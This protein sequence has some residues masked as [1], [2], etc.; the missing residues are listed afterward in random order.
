MTSVM[1]I[2]ITSKIR[3][4]MVSTNTLSLLSLKAEAE[5]LALGI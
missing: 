5:E 2:L 1:T 4:L 3:V